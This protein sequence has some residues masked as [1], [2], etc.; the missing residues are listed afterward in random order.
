MGSALYFIDCKNCGGL[1][2]TDDEYKQGTRTTDCADCEYLL[3]E[4]YNTETG[5]VLSRDE[6]GKKE[7]NAT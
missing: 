4:E 2:C 1:A 6:T 5:E 3:I 7:D